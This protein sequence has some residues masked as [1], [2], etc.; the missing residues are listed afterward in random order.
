MTLTGFVY[1][2]SGGETFDSIARELWEDENFAAD[3]MCANPEHATKQVFTGGEM[4]Y[5]PVVKL[6]EDDMDED[7]TAPPVKA[8]WRE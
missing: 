5:L 7:V 4:L 2:C 3:L 1:T 6:P 8:P